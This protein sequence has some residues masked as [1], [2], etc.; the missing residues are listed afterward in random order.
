MPSSAASQHEDTRLQQ[1][2]C[3]ISLFGRVK[4][5]LTAPFSWLMCTNE[6]NLP[7]TPS[8]QVSP[9]RPSVSTSPQS[10]TSTRTHTA[11]TQFSAS[12]RPQPSTLTS[13]QHLQVSPSSRQD[14]P[15]PSHSPSTLTSPFVSNSAQPPTSTNAQHKLRPMLR[16]IMTSWRS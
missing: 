6:D 7:T 8:D 9:S 15:S 11:R 4:S 16:L 10:L 12:T 3:P 14:S 5:Y 1:D 2:T 13:T